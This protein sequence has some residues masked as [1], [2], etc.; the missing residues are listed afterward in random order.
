[1]SN[2]KPHQNHKFASVPLVLTFV[3]ECAARWYE[4]QNRDTSVA[5][6]KSASLVRSSQMKMPHNE[7]NFGIGTLAT[8][9]LAS[10]PLILTFAKVPAREGMRMLES[11]H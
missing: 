4:C 11:D 6:Q 2:P 5:V 3:N 10:G 9:K 1:M 8:N 7:A